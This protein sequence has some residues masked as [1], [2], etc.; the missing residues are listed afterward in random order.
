MRECEKSWES[1]QVFSISH[2]Q[3]QTQQT[4]HVRLLRQA[5]PEATNREA[6]A[7][8]AWPGPGPAPAAGGA[9]GSYFVISLESCPRHIDLWHNEVRSLRIG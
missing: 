7:T 8:D 4:F 6:D 5:Y 1:L 2:H 3:Q 9:A